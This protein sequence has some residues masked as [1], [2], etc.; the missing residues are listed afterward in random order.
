MKLIFWDHA[1]ERMRERGITI[2]DVR[3][4]ISHP[5]RLDVDKTDHHRLL[6]KRLY[7]NAKLGIR[8]LLMVVYE[9][10]GADIEIVTVVSTSKI[11]KYI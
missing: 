9:A 5:N 2:K 7:Q 10:D 8:Q 11:D 4:T 1:R 3:L 6:A